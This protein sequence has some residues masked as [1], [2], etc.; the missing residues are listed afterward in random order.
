M[1]ERQ[2]EGS[3]YQLQYSHICKEERV[4]AK[5]SSRISKLQ[6]KPGVFTAS[7]NRGAQTDRTSIRIAPLIHPSTTRS[8]QPQAPVA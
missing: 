1:S 7:Y 5:A 8:R 2:A 4:S 6:A 3:N